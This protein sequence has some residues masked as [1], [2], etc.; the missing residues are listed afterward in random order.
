MHD[1]T[2]IIFAKAPIPGETKTRLIP[3]LGIE[4]AAMLHR[5]LVLHTLET[6]LEAG[7]GS[8]EL[9]C[10]P[11]PDHSFFQEC[12]RLY[13]ITLRT[14]QGIDLGQRMAHAI[15]TALQYSRSVIL[16]GTDC[17]SLKAETLQQ[18]V[19]TLHQGVDMVIAPAADGGY[20]LLGVTRSSPDLFNLIAWGTDSVMQT[21]RDRLSKLG[22]RWH[23]LA[24]HQD[25][26]RPEDLEQLLT[27]QTFR[28]L[29]TSIDA[30]LI[31]HTS[32]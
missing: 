27:N 16:I 18:A 30:G 3:G 20:V 12:L 21:T 6:A 1:N 8:V 23:E 14:Q 32:N 5:Q 13:D 28:L 31:K 22:W 9:W 7:I 4:G 15:D 24:E 2:L 26:D 11:A 19:S 10:A 17:P 29:L 25:I